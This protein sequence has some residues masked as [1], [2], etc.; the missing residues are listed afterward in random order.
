VVERAL[1]VVVP[2]VEPGAGFS[3]LLALLSFFVFVGA[4][5]HPSRSGVAGR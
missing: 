4:L 1:D 2:S 5:A 3:S